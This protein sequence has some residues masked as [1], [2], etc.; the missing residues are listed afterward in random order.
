MINSKRLLRFYFNVDGLESALNNLITAYACRSVDCTKGG[1]YWGERIITLIDAKKSL[2]ELWG[3]LDGVLSGF[4]TD[5]RGTLK[6]YALSRFGIS[7][8]DEGKKREI[9]RVLIKF[10]RRARA[11]GRYADGMRLVWEYYCLI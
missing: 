6:N 8:L 5:E 10:T 2:S 3:Y 11:L 9:K 7:R 4:N 1:E